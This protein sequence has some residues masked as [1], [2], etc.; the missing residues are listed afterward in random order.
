MFSANTPTFRTLIALLI[1]AALTCAN[2]SAGIYDVKP[3]RVYLSKDATSA[4]LTIQNQDSAPLR[5][6]LSGLRWINDRSGQPKFTPTDDLIIFP[7]LLRLNP[8]E[9]RNIRVAIAAAPHTG[10]E[11]AYR[12][13]L[14]E[15]PSLESQLSKQSVPGVSV[16][17]RITVP[18][19]FS[20]DT[21][22]QKAKLTEFTI[23]RG[24][25]NVALTNLGNVHLVAES[26]QFR[27]ENSLGSPSFSKTVAGWYVLAGETRDFQTALTR[28]QCQHL[29]HITVTVKTDAGSYTEN[30]D[31]TP[32]DC[33]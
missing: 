7:T 9:T 21:S 25:V 15:L 33:P 3:I 19:F 26:A 28:S 5:L 4:V 27:G 18:I 16:R 32:V 6:Q 17:T 12:V 1:A 20:P 24:L 22:V 10:R 8:F 29:N 11:V 13:M 2:A 23:R 30:R 14:D 31:I